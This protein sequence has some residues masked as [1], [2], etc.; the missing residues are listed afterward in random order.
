MAG[1]EVDKKFNLEQ[2]L[3]AAIKGSIGEK[4]VISPKEVA[5]VSQ[6]AKIVMK[7]DKDGNLVLT[8]KE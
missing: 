5:Q 4:L 2:I 3:A 6:S 1:T 7:L 8:V